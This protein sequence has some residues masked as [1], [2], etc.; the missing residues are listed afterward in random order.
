M[1]FDENAGGSSLWLRRK[2]VMNSLSGH[3]INRIDCREEQEA[4][5]VGVVVESEIGVRQGKQVS[6]PRVVAGRQGDTRTR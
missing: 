1:S 3:S 6:R 5:D 2:E 4:R